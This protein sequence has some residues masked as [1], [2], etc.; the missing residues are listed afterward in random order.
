M[1][2]LTP[3]IIKAIMIEVILQTKRG[4]VVSN[5]DV[6]ISYRNTDDNGHTTKDAAMAEALYFALRE[7]GYN[8]FFSKY[9]ISNDGRS[10]YVTLIN[11]ALESSKNFIAIGTSR[12]NL[13]SKWVKHET[14]TF[15]AL[16]NGS[17]EETRTLLS[18]RSKDFP[19]EELPTSFKAYQSYTDEEAVV[20]FIDVI[21][22]N[23]SSFRKDGDCYLP[24]NSAW[25]NQM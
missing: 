10:D 3:F 16:M 1:F 8:P 22:N 4:G 24:M 21:L 12:K 6:F 25:M 11:E 5:Y 18:Y 15:I 23:A 20:R 14:N 17:E 13:D 7:K 2:I 19:E 9:S